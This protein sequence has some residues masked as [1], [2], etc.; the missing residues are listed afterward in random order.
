MECPECEKHMELVQHSEHIV[1]A[2]VVREIEFDP[3]WECEVCEI[4]LSEEG[5]KL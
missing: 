2:G 4:N 3:V 5:E 1:E